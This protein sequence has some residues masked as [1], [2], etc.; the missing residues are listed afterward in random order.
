MKFRKLSHPK[1]A[2]NS[3]K[4]VQRLLDDPDGDHHIPRIQNIIVPAKNG[5]HSYIFIYYFNN[6]TGKT[7][8]D[9]ANCGNL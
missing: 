7:V 4:Y 9:D 1:K 8:S 2:K 5:L 6:S 3:Y